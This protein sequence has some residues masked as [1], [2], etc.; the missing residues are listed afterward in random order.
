MVDKNKKLINKLKSYW[1]EMQKLQD[2]FYTKLKITS[3]NQVNE[4]GDSNNIQIT[5]GTAAEGSRAESGAGGPRRGLRDA[6]CH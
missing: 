5:G 2:D 4:S 6:R 3:G 1:E